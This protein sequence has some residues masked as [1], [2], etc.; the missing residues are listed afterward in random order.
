MATHNTT[1]EMKATHG[2]HLET[3][4]TGDSSESPIDLEKRGHTAAGSDEYGL[5]QVATQE[6]DAVVT[7]KTWAV[8][9]VRYCNMHAFD[10]FLT[11]SLRCSPLHTAYRFG[12]YHSLAPSKL[13]C[14]LSLGLLQR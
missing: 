6:G 12:Q 3:A 7:A 11:C 5:S 2:H 9:V 1:S 14:L 8:V 4:R 13:R 10:L